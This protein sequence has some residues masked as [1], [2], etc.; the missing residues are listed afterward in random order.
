MS[1][2]ER[3]PGQTGSA[4]GSLVLGVLAA[5]FAVPVGIYSH[6]EQMN[7]SSL[8]SLLPFA[9]LAACLAR[10]SATASSVCP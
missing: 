7:G 9:I 1:N 2:D 4:I 6:D 3:T 8:I 10:M 5:I